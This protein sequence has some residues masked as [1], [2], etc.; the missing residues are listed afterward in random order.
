MTFEGPSR[1]VYCEPLERGTEPAPATDPERAE[2]EPAQ[3]WPEPV[4]PGTSRE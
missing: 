1:R 4:A 3:R 2:P